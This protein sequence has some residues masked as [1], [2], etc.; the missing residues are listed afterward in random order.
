MLDA[1][2]TTFGFGTSLFA[3]F[4]LTAAALCL[5]RSFFIELSFGTTNTTNSLLYAVFHTATLSVVATLH[6]MHQTAAPFALPPTIEMIIVFFVSLYAISIVS[7]VIGRVLCNCFAVQPLYDASSHISG[8]IFN[9]HFHR[10]SSLL[11]TIVTLF[12]YFHIRDIF[13]VQSRNP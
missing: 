6:L 13:C 12:V 4:V 2:F 11:A 5:F 1:I 9:L 10:R 3:A 7:S 8:Q